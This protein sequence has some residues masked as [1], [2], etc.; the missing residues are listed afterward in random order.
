MEAMKDA[1]NITLLKNETDAYDKQQR[2]FT[3][4]LNKLVSDVADEMGI[5]LTKIQYIDGRRLGCK[6]AHLLK[7]GVDG[8]LVSTIIHEAELALDAGMDRTERAKCKIRGLL[9]KLRQQAE[10]Q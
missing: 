1:N 5:T 9:A 4:W 2:Q 3:K 8:N 6:D 10:Y 7:L